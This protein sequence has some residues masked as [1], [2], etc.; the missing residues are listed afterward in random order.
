M[1]KRILP[2]L[3]TMLMVFAM[4]P[5]S[6]PQVYA[7]GEEI[8]TKM[9]IGN[10][11]TTLS[12][13]NGIAYTTA[14]DRDGLLDRKMEFVDQFWT[15][16][17]EGNHEE[18]HI[19]SDKLPVVG[20]QYAFSVI[21]APKTGYAF[22]EEPFE[23]FIYGGHP[24]AADSYMKQLLDNGCIFLAWGVTATANPDDLNDAEFATTV[25]G[26]Q[27][28]TYNGKARTQ[29]VSV[30]IKVHGTWKT[31]KD[32]TDYSVSYKNNKN[33]GTA[34]VLIT[35]KGNFKGTVT[36][37]FKIKKAANPLNVKGKTAQVKLSKLNN[38]DQKL[39]AKKYIK[40]VKKGQGTMKYTLS[41]AK[42]GSKDFKKSFK[43]NSKTGK[44]T[45]RKGLKKG[46]YTLK[47]KVQAKG[48]TNYKKSAVKTVTVKIKVN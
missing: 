48:N 16:M 9:D 13:T 8:I 29:N 38:A 11:W 21:I 28:K 2:I 14:F 42:K 20:H 39:A 30:K 37:T 24:V 45:V 19:G 17:Q 47:V 36:K 18:I 27:S 43:I 22:N 5:M 1:R 41:S 25:S 35:G 33:A 6:L 31:L 10:V 46:T 3:M 4:M 26:I 44:L 40:T 23:K 15:D 34:S 7:D 32:G 12:P